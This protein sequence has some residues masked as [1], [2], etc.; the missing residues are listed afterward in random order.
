MCHYFIAV[1]TQDE[2]IVKFNFFGFKIGGS[3]QFITIYDN[4]IVTTV[5]SLKFKV[6]YFLG[7]DV[8]ETII[9]QNGE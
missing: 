3:L 2:N 7:I 4:Y 5:G 1:F 6:I 8:T 9:L